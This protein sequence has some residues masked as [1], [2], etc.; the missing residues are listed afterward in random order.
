MYERER[1]FKGSRE[2]TEGYSHRVVGLFSPKP[3]GWS[4]EAVAI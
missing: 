1:I 2:E 3:H 4:E